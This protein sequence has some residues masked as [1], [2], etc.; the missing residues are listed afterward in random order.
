MLN[1]AISRRYAKALFEIALAGNNVD[2]LEVELK[3]IVKAIDE[4]ADFK[5]LLFHP[6]IRPEEKKAMVNQIFA[7]KISSSA[8][9]FIN[10]LVDRRREEYIQEIAD[11]YILLANEYRNIIAAK[12]TTAVGLS[13]E[14]VEQLNARLAKV[15][16]KNVQLTTEID[17]T[18]MG[19]VIVRIGDTIMDGSVANKLN[20]LKQK[21]TQIQAKE[22]G[23]SQ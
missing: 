14:E 20:S 2:T 22:I 16:G 21:L 15:T 6:Q 9:D 5:R 17:A 12:V 10:F 23:V 3:G 18:I 11:K 13:P 4:T 7:G 8:L 1:G 19:G